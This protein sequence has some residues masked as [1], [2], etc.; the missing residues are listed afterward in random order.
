MDVDMNHSFAFRASVFPYP[1][2]AAWRFVSIP[3]HISDEI[4][5][6][7]GKIQKGWGSIPVLVR[8]AGTEWET[9]IFPD[10]KSQC[11]LL[12]M[13]LEVRK[14][15]NIMDGD[16]VSISLRVRSDNAGSVKNTKKG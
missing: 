13:K 15:E 16:M 7:F 11:Y 4:K 9:S 2:M 12:P 5:I 8:V 10:K 3:R 6:K 14:K 1:G